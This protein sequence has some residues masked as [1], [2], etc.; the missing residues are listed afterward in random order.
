[1]I[2]VFAVW[3]GLAI[4]SALITRGLHSKPGATEEGMPELEDSQEISAAPYAG[5]G[6]HHGARAARDR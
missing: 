1:M 4:L 6:A 3:A 5:P 2:Y